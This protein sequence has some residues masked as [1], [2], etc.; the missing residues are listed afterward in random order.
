MHLGNS[1]HILNKYKQQ[2]LNR[3][4]SELLTLKYLALKQ[5]T[6]ICK[7]ILI[8]GETVYPTGNTKYIQ[9]TKRNSYQWHI[10]FMSN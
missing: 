6:C 3:I 7:T 2:D 8:S 4:T 5:Y 9:V 1:F 10:S